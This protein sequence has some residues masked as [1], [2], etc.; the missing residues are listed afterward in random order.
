MPIQITASVQ[1]VTTG[2]NSLNHGSLTSICAA[3][4]SW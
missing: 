2:V 1:A 4:W 3:D